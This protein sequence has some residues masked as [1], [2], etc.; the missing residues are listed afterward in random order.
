MENRGLNFAL[1]EGYH[2]ALMKGRFP[3]CC[4]FLEIN[5]AA[6]DVN[7]HPSKRE[8]KFHQEAVVRRHVANAVRQTLL[9]FHGPQP[10]S[11]ATAVE[12]AR[13]QVGGRFALDSRYGGLPQFTPANRPSPT[14]PSS[15]EITPWPSS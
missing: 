3:V 12:N 9:K 4:L 7:I 6:V 10:A 11:A 2:T 15:R 8:V 13:P 14:L 1:M 5:P